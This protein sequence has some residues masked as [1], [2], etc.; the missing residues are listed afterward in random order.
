MAEI[1]FFRIF[2]NWANVSCKKCQ[3]Q[4]LVISVDWEG[5]LRLVKKE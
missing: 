1:V 5:A 3:S 4:L 2:A